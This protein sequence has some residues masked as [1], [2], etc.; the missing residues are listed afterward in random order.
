VSDER[1][2]WTGNPNSGHQRWSKWTFDVRIPG[3]PPS[4]A[5]VRDNARRFFVQL[6]RS[7]A[8]QVRVTQ[9][10]RRWVLELRIEGVDA[11]DPEL[12]AQVRRQVTRDFVAKGFR[13]ACLARMDVGILAGS[14][15]D[16]SPPD[17]LIVLPPLSLM[18]H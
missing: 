4:L 10:G 7:S 8:G 14:R 6:F 12:V 16:G 13:N 5:Y 1:S 3:A 11:H 15:E 18:E 9:F 17:Q 2:A